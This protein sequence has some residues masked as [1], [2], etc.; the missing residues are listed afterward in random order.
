VLSVTSD[1][2]GSNVY[3]NGALVGTTPVKDLER[4]AENIVLK[5]E[6]RGYEPKD[7]SLLL[8]DGE[9]HEVSMRLVKNA[10]PPDVGRMPANRESNNAA[11]PA[12]KT[13]A[14]AGSLIVR[15]I[16]S[17]SV[18]VDGTLKSSNAGQATTITLPAG[19]HTLVMSSPGCGEKKMQI[20]V[21]KGKASNITWYFQAQANIQSLDDADEPLFGTIMVDG[22]N[23]GMFTPKSGYALA[24][25]SHKISVT[26]FGYTTAEGA[27]TV[28][29]QPSRE[30]KTFELVFH[31]K[32][33]QKN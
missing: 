15:A 23:T 32:A 6:L 11:A 16:P 3:I 14:D 26:K 28:D 29:V 5:L 7:S 9:R 18:W 33:G 12:V 27:Q 30:E 17:G 20:D 8:K 1:P 19:A 24:C 2:P 4:N 21:Q 25:G 31:L 10:A 22:V 13:Q